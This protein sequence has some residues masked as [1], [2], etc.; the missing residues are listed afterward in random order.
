[1]ADNKIKVEIKNIS[2]PILFIIPPDNFR[3]EELFETKKIIENAGYKIQI[4]STKTDTLYGMLGGSI[5][6]QLNIENV[7]ENDY[8]ALVLIGGSGTVK[9][10]NNQTIHKIINAFNKNKKIIGAIC[11]APSILARTGILTNKNATV[12]ESEKETFKKYNV[13]YQNKNVVIDDNII[14]SPGPFAVQDFANTL[15]KKISKYFRED[16]FNKNDNNEYKE[17]RIK[18]VD[19]QLK[20][21]DINDEKVLNIMRYLPRHLF[22]PE[23]EQKFGYIDSPVSIGYGQTISQPY[24]VAFMTQAL[25][26]KGDEKVLEIGTGSGYQAAVLAEL[27]KEVYT[28]EII[29]ELGNR[30][31][32]LLLNKM[33]Y[34]NIKVK[35][36]DGY[37]GWIEYAPFDAIIVTAAPDHIP[38]PLIEQLSLNNGKMIIPVGDFYQELILLTKTKTGIKKENLL[39]VRFVPMTG[40]AQK[41]K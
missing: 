2:K 11:L 9:I 36:G 14:T 37:K 21:R 40:E 29:P 33:H 19:L 17:L 7:L 8:S 3:D 10:F 24:I 20:G 25:K 31:E 35:I 38:E 18:M 4:S 15:V 16:Y 41:K 32:D 12:Y 34:K 30:A 39:P 1:M 26:L 13:K 28:I 5:E 23:A 27:A 22:I 6:N